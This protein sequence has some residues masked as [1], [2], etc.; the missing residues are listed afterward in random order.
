MRAEYITFHFGVLFV[1]SADPRQAV[2]ARSE[3]EMT[4]FVGEPS[5]VSQCHGST[6]RV[7][8]STSLVMGHQYIGFHCGLEAVTS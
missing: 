6:T 3:E 7:I 1:T 4:D 5:G 8:G 2:V